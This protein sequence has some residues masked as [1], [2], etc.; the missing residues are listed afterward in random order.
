[1]A[2]NNSSNDKSWKS[3]EFIINV[4]REH[5]RALSNSIE[6][7][8]TVAEKAGGSTTGLDTKLRDVEKKMGLLQKE[9]TELNGY[10]QKDRKKAQ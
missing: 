8:A 1:M 9:I 6:K 7:L 2:G 10:L 5:E 3:L 4:L